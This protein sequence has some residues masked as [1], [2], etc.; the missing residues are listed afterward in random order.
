MQ[1][2]FG[3]SLT[4]IA[5]FLLVVFVAVAVAIGVVAWRN[6]IM[7][8]LG[9]RNIPKRPAQTALIIIGLMLSTVII[10]AAF[11]TGDTVVY[12]IRSIAS[13][14]LGNTDEIVSAGSPGATPGS[15]YFDSSRFGQ[16]SADLSDYGNVDGLLPVIREDAPLIDATSGLSAASV[17][18]FAPDTRSA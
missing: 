1:K 15:G 2:L 5:I 6:R 9:V 4:S 10:T 11:S 18:L 7:F 16:L 14:A 12:T 17:T 13:D 8:K 3:L